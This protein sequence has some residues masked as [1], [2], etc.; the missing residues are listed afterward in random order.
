MKKEWT[1]FLEI[2][3]NTWIKGIFQNFSSNYHH[4]Y[5]Y[6][7][8]DY[9]TLL[10]GITMCTTVKM[11]QRKDRT[12]LSEETRKKFRVSG[13]VANLPFKQ[14]QK[15]AQ[16]EWNL[17]TIHLF[18]VVVSKGCTTTYMVKGIFVCFII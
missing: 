18:A 17:T 6:S 16:E 14:L 3:I 5:I 11:N 12:E 1:D 7:C 4:S 8:K 13:I 2:V 9:H 15:F 10:F